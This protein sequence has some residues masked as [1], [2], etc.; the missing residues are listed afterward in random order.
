MFD[1]NLDQQVQEI[2]AK[3]RDL[4]DSEFDWDGP[5]AVRMWVYDCCAVCEPGYDVTFH[6]VI[7]FASREGEFQTSDPGHSAGVSNPRVRLSTDDEAIELGCV[8][9]ANCVAF[10]VEE[11]EPHPIWSE[12][13][14]RS[15]FIRTSA[16]VVVSP[17]VSINDHRRPVFDDAAK[18]HY[19][20]THISTTG[21]RPPDERVEPLNRDAILLDS[22]RAA[23]ALRN[24]G[25][26]FASLGRSEEAIAA[27]SAVDARFAHA[28]E[29][30]LRQEVASA[31]LRKGDVLL[32][33]GLSGEAI[34]VFE[35]IIARYAAAPEHAVRMQA[36]DAMEK[37]QAVL[38]QLGRNEEAAIAAFDSTVAWASNR[39]QSPAVREQVARA[40]VDKGMMLA[41]L[42]RG[43]DA[44][45]VFDDV[46]SRFGG[47]PEPTIRDQVAR[48]LVSRTAST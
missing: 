17:A 19:Y 3:I 5:S 22:V 46:V 45:K 38:K 40:L 20:A 29:S 44:V 11:R 26:K 16:V 10:I 33:L 7:S 42:G 30:A 32:G 37:K 12:W 39:P 48:A 9:P 27:F 2:N 25:V 31:L 15:V 28:Q 21:F 47:D 18:E 43:D 14:Q 1:H 41:K 8:V 6:D 35:A 13:E 24:E 23:G 4:S 34:A 36:N